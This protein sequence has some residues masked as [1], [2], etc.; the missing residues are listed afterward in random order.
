MLAANRAFYD[1]FEAR[2]LDG[3]AAVWERSERVVCIHPGWPTLRGWDDVMRSWKGLFDGPQRLQFILTNEVVTVQDST[4]WVVVDENLLDAGPGST[5]A[6]VN[7]FAFDG[8]SWRMV[9]HHGSGIA[10]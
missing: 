1:A 2:D 4:A 7:V 3:M 8:T 9:I 6:A 5:I 10:Q